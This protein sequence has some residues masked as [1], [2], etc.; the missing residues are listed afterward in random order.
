MKF[1]IF[2]IGF[3]AGYFYFKTEPKKYIDDAKIVKINTI[4][5]NINSGGCGYFAMKLYQRLD[6]TRY[7]IAVINDGNHISILD[8]ETGFFIDSEGYKDSLSYQLRYPNKFTLITYDSLCKWVNFGKD[9]NK[10]FNRIDTTIINEYI[11]N[12]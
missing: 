10:T 9:W 2:F 6:T 12:L 8:R 5:S 7:S 1:F 3:V 4:V 11:N